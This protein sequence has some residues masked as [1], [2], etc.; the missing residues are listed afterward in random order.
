[1]PRNGLQQ[2]GKGVFT[3]I[4]RSVPVLLSAKECDP[5]RP[6]FAGEKHGVFIDGDHKGCI[7]QY[8]G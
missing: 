3:D 4:L 7:A 1:M 8:M 6:G 5:E 2:R